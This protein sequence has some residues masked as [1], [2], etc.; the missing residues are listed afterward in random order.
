[1]KIISYGIKKTIKVTCK[2]CD[3]ILEIEADDVKT[4]EMLDPC[5]PSLLYI[6]CP[7]CGKRHEISYKE[8]EQ[9]I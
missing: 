6:I 7:V 3:S 2:T 1:M 5:A 8:F 4:Q 9:L